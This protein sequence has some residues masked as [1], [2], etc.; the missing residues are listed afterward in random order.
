LCPYDR[1][2]ARS[3]AEIDLLSHF[4]RCATRRFSAYTHIEKVTQGLLYL[5]LGFEINEGV[6]EG[7]VLPELET[8]PGGLVP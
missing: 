8:K 2:T 6:G 5:T 3:G 7:K 4:P 1:T